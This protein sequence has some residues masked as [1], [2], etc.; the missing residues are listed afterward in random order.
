MTLPILFL[1]S[2]AVGFGAVVSPG[3]VST[4]IVSEA[5][6][7]GFV[8]GPLVAT[9]HSILEFLMV[10]ALALGLRAGLSHPMAQMSIGLAGG[11]L[12]LWMGGDMA[13]GAYKGKIRLPTG[14]P[15]KNAPG[16]S[17]WRLVGLGM[18]ATISN[19]FW[20]AWW[21][22]VAGNYILTAQALGWAGV[23]VFY[24]G[25]ISADYLWDGI[26]S[27]VV[28]SG[29]KWLTDG[30]YRGMIGVCGV[31]L[32]YLGAQFGLAGIGLMRGLLTR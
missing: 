8:V 15:Q 31:Y 30:I 32:V 22:T 6:R 17:L 2:F 5:A 13:W 10:G 19:P 24:F 28:G 29:R 7:K 9:G 26:L 1:F 12:L 27:G 3:P 21:V 4:T 11:A 16:V 14:T 18:V 25:H 23:I 20:Y